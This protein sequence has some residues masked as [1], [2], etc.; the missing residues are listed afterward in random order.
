MNE[1]I[2]QELLSDEAVT[3]GVVE[4][5]ART[6][7]SS[8]RRRR[9]ARRSRTARSV[10]A[11]FFL[12]LVAAAAGGIFVAKCERDQAA[13]SSERHG[14]APRRRPA[15]QHCP[16]CGTPTGRRARASAA[17]ADSASMHP[18]GDASRGRA[19]AAGVLRAPAAPRR[20]RRQ[21][22]KAS[23]P[24]SKRAVEP[25]A[26]TMLEQRPAIR[27]GPLAAFAPRARAA[28]CADQCRAHGRRAAERESRRRARCH[29]P[30]PRARCA[31]QPRPAENFVGPH[32]QQPLRRRGQDRRRRLRR[33]LPR[34][35]DRHRARGRAQDPAPAQLGRPD[36]R[37]ALPPR[38]RGVLAS[39]AIRTRS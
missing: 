35:A 14:T 7:R 12:A 33:R 27:G 18:R 3:E 24:V 36:D 30:R 21:C 28:G 37:R 11:F 25:L 4:R 15:M 22:A 13:Q 9:R 10:L 16:H 1:R 32:A 19:R 34:Q 29:R 31:R 39:C 2:P 20:R 26:A 5:S 23:G 6:G 17:R 8:G 38:G